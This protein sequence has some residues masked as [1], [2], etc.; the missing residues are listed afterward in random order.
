MVQPKRFNVIWRDAAAL[1]GWAGDTQRYI[2]VLEEVLGRQQDGTA[3]A[4]QR[5]LE[6]RRGRIRTSCQVGT[7]HHQG[8]DLLQDDTA[9]A[10]GRNC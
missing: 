7:V 4:L 1:F 6:Q 8:P 3:E 9:K 2:S 5:D 10:L